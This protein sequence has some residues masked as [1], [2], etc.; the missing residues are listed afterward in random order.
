MVL[1]DQNIGRLLAKLSLPAIAG[2]L[3]MSLYN[4]VDAI[5]I[6]QSVGILGIAGIAIAFPI[7]MIVGAVGQ[8]IGIGGASL[9]SRSL[10]AKNM[11]TANQILGNVIA[12]VLLLSVPISCFGLLGIN[13]L[14]RWFGATPSIMPYAKDYLL[15]ILIGIT[16]HSMAMALNNLVRAE[17]KAKIAMTTMILS[18]VINIIL[19]AYFIF[20]L[21]MGIRGA[22]IATL[23]AY[24]SGFV[25][26]LTYYL[27]GKSVLRL[28][29]GDIGFQWNIQRQIIAIGISAF[30]RQ[31]AM[32]L[33]VIILNNSLAHHGGDIAIAVYGVV[34]RLIWLLFTPILGISQ[35]LQ[36]IIGFNY[37]AKNYKKAKESVLLATIVATLISIIGTVV[38][39]LFPETL[40]GIFSKDEMLLQ[41]GRTALR[42]IIL[43]FP[44]MGF[45]VIG[46]TLFQA[47]GKAVQT[48]IL[49]LS[50]QFIFLIPLVLI[51][52]G[53]FQLT[54]IWISFPIADMLSAIMTL[55]MMIPL[56]NHY[57]KKMK[58]LTEEFHESS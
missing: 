56:K 21:K 25:F 47:I 49:T 13:D 2:M 23:I 46:I 1:S 8:M 39:L 15:Y 29:L 5:F 35:G 26:L 19:D 55:L 48:F 7:Q 28:R 18:S 30:I 34:M 9:L 31:A 33:L 57:L 42:Y 17:G 6:G 20:G 58:I 22:A 10:G 45:H 53:F 4:V 51:L 54:G 40:L 32:S 12:S 50:R 52:P 14:L 3:V 37:G 27:S 16:F 24:F 11:D 43:A 44:L 36:P 38:I 41:Q